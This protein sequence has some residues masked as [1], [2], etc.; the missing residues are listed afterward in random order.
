M[1]TYLAACWESGRGGRTSFSA[2]RTQG[3]ARPAHSFRPCDPRYGVPQTVCAAP[4]RAGGK[5][6]R[7][8]R[9]GGRE[10][11]KGREAREQVCSV[12]GLFPA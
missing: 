1:A 4:M 6:R 2:P 7:E 9:E 5:A 11:R 8:A 12:L 10:G 3:R